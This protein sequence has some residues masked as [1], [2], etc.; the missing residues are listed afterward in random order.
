[1]GQRT[2]RLIGASASVL[3]VL[4]GSALLGCARED[5]PDPADVVTPEPFRVEIG[6]AGPLTGDGAEYGQGMKRAIDLAIK[7]ANNSEEVRRAG[8]EFVV[9]AEDDMGDP[10]V[11]AEV[12]EALAEDSDVIGVVGH[13]DAE[14][15]LSAARVYEEAGMAMVTVSSAPELTDQELAVVNRI[16]TRED[17]QGAIAAHMLLDDLGLTRVA[18]IDDST[19][20]GLGLGDRFL[21]AFTS[22]GGEAVMRESIPAEEEVDFEALVARLE[23]LTPQALYYAGTHTQGALVSK[24]VSEAELDIAIIGGHRILC[25]EYISL[26]EPEN[27]EGDISTMPGL[28]LERQAR[29]QDFQASFIAEYGSPPEVYDSYAYDATA[30][31]IQAVLDV[32]PDRESVA[33]AVREMTFDGVT[34]VT[35]FDERGENLNQAVSIFRVSEGEWAELAD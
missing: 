23:E 32:G 10:Q 28:P 31:F 7:E 26:A 3:L 22:R 9:R 8:Y 33:K 4:A 27:A 2:M 15:S 5:P 19:S 21:E 1:M 6:F 24:H 16:F 25:D 30:L 29:G 35:Q 18:V 13:L 11:A 34:G 12:A 14:C 20:Y 17:T